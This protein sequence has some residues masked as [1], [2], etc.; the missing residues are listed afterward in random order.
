LPLMRIRN[1]HFPVEYYIALRAVGI[2]DEEYKG[3]KC[4][5]KE[6]G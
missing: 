3:V 6:K 5:C 2:M 1:E 4:A